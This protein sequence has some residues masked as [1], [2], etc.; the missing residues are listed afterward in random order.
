MR[1]QMYDNLLYLERKVLNIY[2]FMSVI[3]KIF[4]PLQ[5][6]SVVEE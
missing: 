2:L 6:K 5:A 4:V 3:V 1:L